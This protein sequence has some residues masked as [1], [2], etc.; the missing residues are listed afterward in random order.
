MKKAAIKILLASTPFL[1]SLAIV[2]F[3]PC[4]SDDLVALIAVVA[5]LPTLIFA[6]LLFG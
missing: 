2:S 3:S 5:L 1:G 4:R 6:W